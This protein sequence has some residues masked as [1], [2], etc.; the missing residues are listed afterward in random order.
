MIQALLN[1]KIRKRLSWMMLT[2]MVL[3]MVYPNVSYALSSGPV[4]PEV[5]SFEPVGTTD[6]VDMFTGDFVY[7]IP[8]LDVEGYPI[9]ISYHGGVTMDQEASW[10]GLGWN[11]SPGAVNRALR[12]LPDEFAGDTI[13]KELNI[14]K[15]VTTRLGLAANLEVLGV[16]NPYINVGVSLGGYLTLSNYR[17][18]S[19]DFTTSAGVNT[20]LFGVLSGGLNVGASLGS[21]TGAAVNY[22]LM[23]GVGISSNINKDLNAS[24]S[25][26]LNTGGT[27]SPRTGLRRNVGFSIGAGLSSKQGSLNLSTGANVQIA[28]Q[29]YSAAV[30]NASYMNSFAG[31]FK[32]GG[33]VFGL[34][35]AG[36]ASGSVTNLWYDQVGSRRGYGYFNLDQAKEGDL[37]DFSR[38]KDGSFNTTMFLLPQTHLTYDVY[39][40]TG[41]G[42]GGSFRP[43][44]NDIGAVYDPVTKSE[45]HSDNAGI[46]GGAGNLFNVGAEYT[47][48]DASIESG[49]WDNYYR[50]FSGRDFKNPYYEDVYFKEAGELT[51]NNESY[52]NSYGNTDVIKPEDIGNVPTTKPDAST[53]IVRA[54]HIYTRTY[55]LLDSDALTSN[56]Q[57]VSYSDTTGFANYPN[58]TKEYISRID[59][60][61]SKKLKRKPQQV[62][63]IV[64]TQKDGR[65]YVYGL[66]VLNNVQREMT[67]AVDTADVNDKVDMKRFLISYKQGTDD[68]RGN[69]H[70][71]DHFY[72]STV[73]PTYVAAHLLT[74]VL[75]ADYV[76][77]TGDGISDDDLGTY[78][79][80]NYTR[81][82]TDYRWRTPMEAGKAQFMPGYYSDK[83]DD[84]AS[85][86][87]GSREQWMLHSIETKNYVAEFYVSKRNDAMG[88]NGGIL[89]AGVTYTATKYQNLPDSLQNVSYKLDSIVLYNKH[90]RFLHTTSAQRSRP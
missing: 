72:S 21:Q 51:Q 80:F 71:L 14:K 39:G 3:E 49:H 70:G 48:T 11:I 90:D 13:E 85:V 20:Q 69:G 42:T 9:N 65:R 31:H 44:R 7:N 66:P 87:A 56:K 34:L 67:F 61:A 10:V 52:L 63:E 15:E 40:V 47:E 19:V 30:T 77:V 18:V 50:H 43:F 35:F 84:K 25:F 75:S 81:K 57:L 76:D 54:N 46:E 89:G 78:T 62:T 38:E 24:G 8:L 86:L 74:G 33:E 79:K 6:M 68:S 88:Y 41:Q 37:L 22:N 53:R 29:N 28:N 1:K 2:V 12:G 17:G 32:L 5:Q 26:N 27:Y 83:M 58:I 59:N 64:Q 23:G 45:Q 73:T 4:Q 16:G 36:D 55:S 60:D 82:S